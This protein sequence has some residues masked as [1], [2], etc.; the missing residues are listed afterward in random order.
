MSTLDLPR[1][2]WPVM[3]TPFCEDRSID[4]QGVDA[5]T[6]WYIRSG[7]AGLFAVCLS[8]EMYELTADE[9]LQLARRV[10]ERAAGRVPVVASGTFGG[11]LGAQAE[12]VRR[13]AGTGV[14]AVVVLTCQLA[15]QDQDDDEWRASAEVLLARTGE[16]PLGLYEC[17]VPYKRVM[18]PALMRWAGHT[19]R[20]FFHKDTCSQIEPIRTKIAAVRGTPFRFFNANAASLLESLQAGG[21]GYSG[22]AVNY[23]PQL[24]VWLCRHFQDQPEQAERLQRFLSVAEAVVRYKYPASAKTFLAL[25]GLGITPVCRVENEP[26]TEEDCRILRHLH[27]CSGEVCAK[28]GLEPTRF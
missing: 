1:G 19:G 21:D 17:P 27:E 2:V 25:A 5:L 7:G 22:I 24:Y 3:I 13:M 26:L 16:I 9:R 20:I 28:L 23:F 8:S 12:F 11:A 10:V 18:S 14:S 6:D 15:G 4:W